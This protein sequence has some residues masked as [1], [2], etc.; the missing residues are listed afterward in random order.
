MIILQDELWPGIN[1]HWT[2]LRQNYIMKTDKKC[3]NLIIILSGKM[4]MRKEKKH[5]KTRKISC[6]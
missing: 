3:W 5:M 6:K 1:T 2:L 4:M